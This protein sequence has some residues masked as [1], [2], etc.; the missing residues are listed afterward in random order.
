MKKYSRSDTV[1]L[2][3]HNIVFPLNNVCISSKTMQRQQ[4]NAKTVGVPKQVYLLMSIS[5]TILINTPHT[6]NT[7][8]KIKIKYQ[9]EL[10]LPDQLHS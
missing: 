9:L 3:V 5:L 10:K 8:D 4:F 1:R 6:A 7:N 2:Y